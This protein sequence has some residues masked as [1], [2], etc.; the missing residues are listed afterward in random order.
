[1]SNIV[2]NTNIRKRSNTHED[3]FSKKKRTLSKSMS[4]YIPIHSLEIK[5]EPTS[6]IFCPDQEKLFTQTQVTELLEREKEKFKTILEEKLRE[7]FNIFNQF[8]VENIFKEYKN[9]DAS[10][11]N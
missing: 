6:P 2:K 1:M 4:F 11:I 7:Q 3:N 10:Y 5:S 8:Y 9:T